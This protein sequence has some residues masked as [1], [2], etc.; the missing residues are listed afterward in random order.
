MTVL[1]SK[2]AVWASS[3]VFQPTA[4]KVCWAVCALAGTL[5]SAVTGLP[6]A[7]STVPTVV[8]PSQLLKVLVE[9]VWSAVTLMVG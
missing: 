3:A 2:F 7:Y 9:E 4:A 1:A 5:G 6:S 8:E